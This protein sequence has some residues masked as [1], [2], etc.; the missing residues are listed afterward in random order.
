MFK[1]V[2]VH[3]YR[4]VILLLFF[5]YV[6]I[7]RDVVADVRCICINELGNWMRVYPA[8]FLED[9]YLKYIGWSLFDKVNVFWLMKR[10]KPYILVC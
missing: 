8:Y 2:F 9:S 3:R 1:S 5:Y 7:V 6:I 10:T 4:L